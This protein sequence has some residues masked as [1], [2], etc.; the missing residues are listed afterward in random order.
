M[1]NTT[2]WDRV[3]NVY[4]I[5]AQLD[6]TAEECAELIVAVEKI[7]RH[8]LQEERKAALAD[9]IADVQIML[10][11]IT[12]YLEL[13]DDVERIRYEKLARLEVRLP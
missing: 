5:A 8:G 13:K 11:Q 4:G 9:E 3:L 10:E 7:K 6:M 2:L 1:S 12:Y